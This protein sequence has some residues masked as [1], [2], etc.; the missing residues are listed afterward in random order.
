[1]NRIER[2]FIRYNMELFILGFAFFI[3]LVLF[4]FDP[5]YD[6]EFKASYLIWGIPLLMTIVHYAKTNSLPE[7]KGIYINLLWIPISLFAYSFIINIIHNGIL[8]GEKNHINSTIIIVVVSWIVLMK[9][10]DYQRYINANREM[11]KIK[12]MR[13]FLSR[14]LAD[15]IEFFILFVTYWA[16]FDT[17]VVEIG[18]DHIYI[19]ILVFVFLAMPILSIDI[20]SSLH[21]KIICVYYSFIITP[22]TLCLVIHKWIT[23]YNTGIRNYTFCILTGLVVIAN[24]IIYRNYLYLKYK[25]EWINND[26]M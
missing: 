5:K 23:I 17:Y 10:I 26:Q 8:N 9:T 24:V 2:L 7:K 3:S 21:L 19:R 20:L 14:F 15:N 1:M 22:I 25:S 11:D 13:R 12:T 16:A 6:L 18:F 4:V